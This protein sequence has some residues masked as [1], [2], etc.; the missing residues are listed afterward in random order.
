V[1]AQ[2]A[3]VV[4]AATPPPSTVPD[5][6]VTPGVWGF[7]ITA[8]VAI[9]VVLLIV[10]MTRRIRRLRYRGEVLE[11]IEQEKAQQASGN[12]PAD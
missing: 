10:D 12:G 2:L 3:H 8:A 5:D 7:V 6:Q 9:I 11:K 4:A 1:L